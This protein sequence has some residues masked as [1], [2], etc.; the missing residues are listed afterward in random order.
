[1]K[2][3]IETILKSILTENRVKNI[4]KKYPELVDSTGESPIIDYFIAND[5]SGNNKYLEWMIKAITHKPTTNFAMDYLDDRGWE[6]GVWGEVAG[7]IVQVVKHFH[8]LSPYIVYTDEDGDQRGSKDLYSYRL[9]DEGSLRILMN[10]LNEANKKKL[11]S[12]AIKKA[13]KESDKIYETE[14]WL[15]IRPKSWLASCFYGAGTKWCTTEKKTDVHFIRE[16][17]N[18]FLI[19][20]I[21]KK[22]QLGNNYDKVAWQISYKKNY[23][24][25][26]SNDFVDSDFVKLWNTIDDNFAFQAEPYLALLPSEL[27]ENIKSYVQKEINIV[28]EKK[29]FYEDP[30]IQAIINMIGSSDDLFITKNNYSHYGLDAYK[31]NSDEE[32]A[33]FAVGTEDEINAAIIEYLEGMYDGMSDSEILEG[34][35]NVEKYITFDDASEIARNEASYRIEDLSDEE[36]LA[37]ASSERKLRDRVEAYEINLGIKESNESEIEELEDKE[38]L[39]T[40]ESEYLEELKE[41]NRELTADLELE[42]KRIR[43]ALYRTYFESILYRLENEPLDWLWEM[44]YYNRKK[45]QFEESTFNFITF[46]RDLYFSDMAENENAGLLGEDGEYDYQSVNGVR[47]YIVRVND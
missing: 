28:I 26:M 4:K 37:E 11:Q 41:E 10:D 33:V 47:Y 12:E 9:I 46:D 45:N 8:E 18:N 13:K 32:T 22:N 19:Y 25:T 2:V 14:D 1:M 20:V 21:N 5:P 38:E 7:L 35:R 40:E 15:V 16:T 3:I 42:F 39:T 43:D 17:S 34:V 31:V 24:Q 6:E 27:I 29:Q 44:G 23:A 30:K 36:V